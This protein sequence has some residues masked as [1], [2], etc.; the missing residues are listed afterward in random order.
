MTRIEEINR[1]AEQ[2]V[3]SQST[4]N[5]LSYWT[6]TTTMNGPEIPTVRGWIM[7]EIEARFP[8]I[9]EQWLDSDDCSDEEL[10]R[11]IERAS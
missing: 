10:V 6:M 11:M 5:L 2:M 4:E 3:K 7:D 8:E 1:K 9:Y